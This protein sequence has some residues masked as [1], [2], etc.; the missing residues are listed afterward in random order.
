MINSAHYLFYNNGDLAMF[1]FRI[2]STL[3]KKEEKPEYK[4][5]EINHRECAY[6]KIAYSNFNQDSFDEVSLQQDI[7]EAAKEGLSFISVKEALIKPNQDQ[8]KKNLKV[9]EKILLHHQSH[10]TACVQVER[11]N[12][13]Q[14][15][16][17]EYYI[18]KIKALGKELSKKSL[19][20]FFSRSPERQNQID[21]MYYLVKQY[22]EHANGNLNFIMRNQESLMPIGVALEVSQRIKQAH[23]HSRIEEIVD[24][25]QFSARCTV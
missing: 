24:V 5:E 14:Q 8:T 16:V 18:E 4:T 13:L 11:R 2:V 17:W 10:I 25:Q 19:T 15:F 23:P 12:N 7:L 20:H 6:N 21:E 22:I 9:L 1:S 3:D